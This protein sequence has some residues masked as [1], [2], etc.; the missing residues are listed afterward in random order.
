ML[1]DSH[2]QIA[3]GASILALVVGP[4]F[5]ALSQKSESVLAFLRG[6]VQVAVVGMVL[7]EVMPATVG[8]AGPMA[9]GM[10]VLGY[11]LPGVLERKQTGNSRVTQVLV[12]VGLSVHAF[13]DGLALV[14]AQAHGGEGVHGHGHGLE[15]AIILH[16]I[17]V[18]LA[19]FWMMQSRG[20][21]AGLLAVGALAGATILGTWFGSSV[22]ESWLGASEEAL[23]AALVGGLLMHVIRGESPAGKGSP[24]QAGVG[25]LLGL[26]GVA[27]VVVPGWTDAGSGV[28]S[29]IITTFTGLFVESAPALLVAYGLAGALGGMLGEA[30]M[31]WMRQG[32]A[33]RRAMKGVAFGL[34]L[35]LCSC[36]VVPVYQ[37]LIRRGT[38]AAAA[39][40]FLVATPELGLDAILISLPMLG[41]DVAIARVIAAAVVAMFVGWFVGGWIDRRQPDRESDVPAVQAA[42]APLSTRLREGLRTGFID[43]V[44]DSA[45]WI[46]VGLC[47]A[48]ILSPFL[49]PEAFANISPFV[50]VPLF[51][52]IGAPIYVCATGATPLAA[53]LIAK[54]A[55]PGAALAFLLTGPATNA[56]TF[57][58]LERLHGRRAAF[59]FMG[60]VVVSVV[61]FGIGTDL[62]LG[63][64]VDPRAAVE[65]HE[66]GYSTLQLVCAAALTGLFAASLVR[67][68]PGGFVG[69]LGK[70]TNRGGDHDHSHDGHDHDD[71]SSSESSCCSSGS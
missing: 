66:H 49:K 62:V 36:G 12:L 70:L 57:G 41:A 10:L 1:A 58:V 21:A 68:G 8:A 28:R 59:L 45:T 55:S 29:D 64:T 65:A 26:L 42:P 14:G 9:L 3:L 47:L 18:G 30:S 44:D 52:V 16:R 37:S 40:S 23:L 5:L 53:I 4:A 50:Q 31:R 13:A 67:Q 56:T 48:A 2:L 33:A 51:A 24:Q 34:P 27:A 63:G 46:L 22:I 39:V 19:I 54:G 17:A 7:L 69:Q 71:D 6:F 35:P 25:A 15:A 60:A 61:T 38:P 43:I 32:G 11:L 20:K